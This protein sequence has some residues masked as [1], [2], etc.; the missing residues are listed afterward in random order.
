MHDQQQPCRK[1]ET[2]RQSHARIR[3]WQFHQALIHAGL[4]LKLD[5][6]YIDVVEMLE[7]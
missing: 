4:I 7:K 3:R 2:D 5:E 6:I 1:V